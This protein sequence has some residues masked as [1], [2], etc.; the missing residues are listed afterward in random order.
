M[1]RGDFPENWQD[2][3]A[4]Y[5]L[6]NLSA[7][8]V[9]T[10]K[11][12]L[13][14][15]PE[16]KAELLAYKR[17]L[18]QLPV[19]LPLQDPPE[20]LED[21]LLEAAKQSPHV[22]LPQMRLRVPRTPPLRRRRWAI[23]S[24]AIV[25]TALIVLGT[26]NWRLRQNLADRQAQLRDSK[27]VIEHLQQN[28]ENANIVFSTLRQPTSQVHTMQ[29]TNGLENI[30]GRLIIVPGHSEVALVVKNMP[31]QPA[32]KIYRLWA[33]IVNQDAPVY[34]GQFKANETGAMH[35]VVPESDCVAN[36]EQMMIT[37]DQ[38]EAPP[39]FNNELVM[40]SATS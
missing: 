8:E 20:S 3:L 23:A 21:D 30:S 4:G 11:Q 39:R 28:I 10:L 9:E 17:A 5:A 26:D 15:H 6:N 14:Q 2:L 27:A 16:F 1:N 40:R 36:P 25:A 37:I 22:A 12:L 32:D 35:W 34:C 33:V 7:E 19:A 18:D 38:L 31:Q 13:A 24:W 29:G